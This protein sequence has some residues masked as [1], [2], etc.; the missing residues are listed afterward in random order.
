V[1]QGP[2]APG[3][4]LGRW[5]EAAAD[6]ARQAEAGKLAGQ[7]QA[8]L[9]GARPAKEKDPDRILYDN[10]VSPDSAVLK[11]VE[12]AR[13]VKPRPKGPSYGLAKE[14]FGRHSDGK[15]V[16]AASFVA[17]ANTVTEVRLPAALFRDR[18][19]VVEGKLDAPPGERVV[20][21][22]VRGTDLKSVLLPWDGKSPVVASPTGAA[23]KQLLQGHADFRR[24][25]PWFICFPNVVPTDEVVSL[26]MFHREDEALERLLLDDEQK[27]RIDHLWNEHRF[28]SQQPVTENNYLPQFIGFVTQDQPKELLDYF[29]GQR[30][31]F[32]RADEFEKDRLA[33]E[34]KHLVGLPDFAS[35]AFRRPL[36]EKEKTEL[37]ALYQTL[38]KKGAAHGEALRG[39]LARVL[40]SPSFL[41][42]IER[43]PPG[44]EPGP[45]NDW[46]LA[47]RLS[48][49]LWSS[50]PD[51]EL[52]Q[53]ADAGKL[54]DP[55]VLAAQTQRMLKD[56]A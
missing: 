17:A 33:A 9:T 10:L 49:F 48:Y 28:I 22:Q 16:E 52:R 13:F 44:T 20:Q 53:L 50:A 1:V 15:P 4:V 26:K 46:E 38:R 23:F 27:R 12:L 36:Q 7:V 24:Y 31:V 41:F 19:F 8:L 43:A 29:E 2:I 37:L 3:S 51:D 42:R 55:K 56:A 40:V 30:P 34:P 25:F 5:R 54:R 6:S 18:E 47:T 32:K 11:G 39:V 21:F 14:R 35:R 45:I